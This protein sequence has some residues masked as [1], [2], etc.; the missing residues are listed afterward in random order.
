VLIGE[1]RRGRSD[2][3]RLFVSALFCAKNSDMFRKIYL[4]ALG[5]SIAVMAFFSYYSWSWL[6]SIGQPAAA[7]AGYEY[8]AHLAWITLWITTAMLLILGNAVLWTT[9]SVWALWITCLYFALFVIVRFFVLGRAF[10]H[11]SET[12]STFSAGP[13]IGAGL[14]ILMAAFVLFDSFIV[15]RLLARFYPETTLTETGPETETE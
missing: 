13:I 12:S 5:L 9:R 6:Q 2:R 11:F 8:H 7:V 3:R 4:V 14:I 1:G 15:V 10:V